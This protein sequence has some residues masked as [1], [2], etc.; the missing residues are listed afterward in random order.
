MQKCPDCHS[1]VDDN[2]IFCDQCGYR[3]TPRPS[4]FPAVTSSPPGS[5]DKQTDESA[6][7][8]AEIE[9]ACPSC[10]YV[11]QP[12]E[13]FCVNCGTQLVRTETSSH[14]PVVENAVLVTP[15]KS[16]PVCGA[17]NLFKETYCRNCGFML[18]PE[19]SEASEQLL[20]NSTPEK[21]QSVVRSEPAPTPSAS[22]E[23]ISAYETATTLNSP[24]RLVS[25]ATN[26][27]L[28]LPAQTDI[29]I[30]RQ[31][32]ERGIYPDIDLSPQG[33][34]ASSVSRQHARLYVQGHQVF[35][36]DLNSTNSTFLNRRRLQ[37]GQRYLLNQGDELRLGGVILVFYAS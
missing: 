13:T 4:E 20:V 16:C 30:G 8:K 12:G 7:M 14:E 21:E 27:S 5:S 9:T 29:V 36:E 15:L 19:G 25:A 33:S 23:K 37:P 35:V 24:G 10:G 17:D 6:T 32:A 22:P 1:L 34:V 18:I 31:D 3:L 28:A 26:T 11:N 2:A